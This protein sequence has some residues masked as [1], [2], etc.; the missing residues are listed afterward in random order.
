MI[1]VL[2]TVGRYAGV[3]FVV[4]VSMAI[5]AVLTLAVLGKPE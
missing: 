4:G 2:R 1:T 3:L 5:G